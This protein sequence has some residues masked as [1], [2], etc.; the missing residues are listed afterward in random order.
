ML[1]PFVEISSLP[2]DVAVQILLF[3]DKFLT[4]EINKKILE[5]TQ[6]SSTMQ[7]GLIR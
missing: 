7:V 1:R 5:L 6:F 3:G 2:N 4:N